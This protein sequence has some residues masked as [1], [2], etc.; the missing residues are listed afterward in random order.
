MQILF[1][2]TSI[3]KVKHTAYYTEANR[4]KNINWNAPRKKPDTDNRTYHQH[5]HTLNGS[6]LEIGN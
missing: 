5:K 1:R 4:N 6:K 2:H 3:L